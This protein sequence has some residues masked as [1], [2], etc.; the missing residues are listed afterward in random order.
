MIAYVVVGLGLAGISF[1]EMLQKHHKSFLVYT[2]D[3]QSASMVAGGLYNPVILKRFS[4]VWQ[5]SQ[6]LDMALPFYENLEKKLQC[7]LDYKIPVLRR[8]ASLQ[9]QNSWF[10]A[11]DKSLLKSFLSTQL[12]TNNN[13]N[14]DAPHGFGAVRHTGRIATRKLILQYKDHLRREKCLREETFNFEALR[15]KP[16]HIQYKDIKAKHIVFATGFGLTQNP[17][18]N[19]LPLQGSKGELLT[20]DAPDL[21]ETSVIK[22][23]VFSIP[24]GAHQYKIGATYQWADKTPAITVEAKEVLLNKLNTFVRCSYNVV[25]Q[26]AGIRPT[27]SDRR[28]LV[29]RHPKYQQLYVLNGFGSRGVMI[30]PFAAHQLFQHI[31]KGLPLDSEMDVSRFNGK[32]P[33]V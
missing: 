8:F 30:A 29:G 24:L 12:S 1:C 11:A 16:D 7:K 14:I 22:S 32:F 20:I 9:E 5:A 19:Y 2:D 13:P 27:V 4:P 21:K 15:L 3:S 31:E 10:E 25:A 17:Y 33:L 6:Q 26:E 18:F 23:S 28:P